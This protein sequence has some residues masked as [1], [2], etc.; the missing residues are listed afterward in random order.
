MTVSCTFK[1]GNMRMVGADWKMDGAERAIV[2][3]K[4]S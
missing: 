1:P 3:A 4:S 2:G